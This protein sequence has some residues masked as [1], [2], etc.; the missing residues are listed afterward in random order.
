MSTN[1][2]LQNK[3][4]EFKRT[5]RKAMKN[6]QLALFIGAGVSIN[7]GMPSWQN[8]VETIGKR[9]GI[10]QVAN[11]DFLKIPQYYYNANGKQAYNSLMQEIFKYRV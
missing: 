1:K 4:T 7:S 8:A 5:I 9:L 10:E 3:Y 2:A 6:N 11:T